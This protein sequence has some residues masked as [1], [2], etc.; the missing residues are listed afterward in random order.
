MELKIDG[1]SCSHCQAAV[2]GALASVAGVQAVEVDLGAGL[3][4]IEGSAD[5]GALIRAVEEEGYRASPA[6][7]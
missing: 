3:A 5:L 1:M 7:S 6:S 4:K 2:K